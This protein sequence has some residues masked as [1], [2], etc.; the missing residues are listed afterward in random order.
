MVLKIMF[1]FV[2]GVQPAAAVELADCT[3]TTHISHGGQADHVDLGEGRV[4]WRDWW[5]Q[6]GTATDFAIVEC[7]TGE[8]LRFRTAE[9]NMGTRL[10][11]D[12]T[13]DALAILGRHQS[14]ARAFATFDRIAM[15][16]KG[17]AKDIEISTLTREPCACAA[18]YGD[19]RGDKDPFML[20]G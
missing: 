5:S 12:R 11:F 9:T 2:L 7:G 20:G 18:L 16:L 15:D 3:R 6:E 8:T 13:D 19:L 4:M 1:S 14:G 10:P 17:V